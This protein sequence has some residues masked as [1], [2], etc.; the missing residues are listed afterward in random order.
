MVHRAMLKLL[1]GYIFIGLMFHRFPLRK[2][3]AEGHKVILKT[4][5]I[6]A[7]AYN[8]FLY[9]AEVSVSSSYLPTESNFPAR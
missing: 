5:C 7:S 1:K 6:S 3:G 8:I 9:K 4:S 2:L